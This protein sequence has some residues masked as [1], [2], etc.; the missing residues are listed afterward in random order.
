MNRIFK[1]GVSVTVMLSAF[2]CKKEKPV[3]TPSP[4]TPTTPYV[5][6]MALLTAHPWYWRWVGRDLDKDGEMDSVI[7]PWWQRDEFSIN[8]DGSMC[9][10][11]YMEDT[12]L[13]KS[14]GTWHFIDSNHRL[15]VFEYS[16][17]GVEQYEIQRINDTS[18]VVYNGLWKFMSAYKGW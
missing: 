14:C 12:I 5:D 9:Y 4:P 8:G 17:G 1:A 6:T 10:T 11:Q 2:A 13:Q 18:L 7:S 15:F 16:S 3:N